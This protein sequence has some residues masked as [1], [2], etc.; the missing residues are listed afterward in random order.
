MGNALMKIEFHSDRK[1]QQNWLLF[2]FLIVFFSLL[3]LFSANTDWEGRDYLAIRKACS[4][5]SAQGWFGLSYWDK[6]VQHSTYNLHYNAATSISSDSGELHTAAAD[7]MQGAAITQL[8]KNNGNNSNTSYNNNSRIAVYSNT[9]QL[10]WMVPFSRLMQRG[11]NT[12]THTFSNKRQRGIKKISV[13][14]RIIMSASCPFDNKR[15]A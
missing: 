15:L 6:T 8:E 9:V 12:H 4:Q 14:R 2:F 10:L 5:K 7:S 3:S 1:L 11:I 13:Q